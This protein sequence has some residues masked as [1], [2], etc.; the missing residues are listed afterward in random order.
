[1]YIKIL[2]SNNSEVSILVSDRAD[3]NGIYQTLSFSTNQ[4]LIQN[5]KIDNIVNY[6]VG[7]VGQSR[8]IAFDGILINGTTVIATL[9]GTSIEV[10]G[11]LIK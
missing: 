2:L 5:L 9:K 8:T 6:G 1:M 7:S 4:P 10:L 11:S 3:E